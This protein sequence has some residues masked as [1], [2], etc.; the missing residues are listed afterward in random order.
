MPKYAK[1]TSVPASRT[2]T[3]IERTLTR[4]GVEEFYYGTSSKGSG[5]AFKYQGRAYKMNVPMPKEGDYHTDAQFKQVQRQMWRILLLALKAKLELVDAG[6]I[7]FED[8]F[9]A[10]TCLPNGATVGQHVQNTIMKSLETGMM[11]HKLLP[12]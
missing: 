9:L 5:I 2:K 4:Y 12:E 6:M 7:T 10:Q 3:E 1:G 8:E 11:P